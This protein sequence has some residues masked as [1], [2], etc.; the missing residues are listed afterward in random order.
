MT[1]RALWKGFITSGGRAEPDSPDYLR[2]TVM[3]LA[4]GTSVLVWLLFLVVNLSLPV[5]RPAPRIVLNLTGMAV[6]FL[7]ILVLR[8]GA[9]IRVMA[10]LVQLFLFVMLL[11]AALVKLNNP[12]AISVP[13]IYPAIAFLLLDSVPRGILWNLLMILCLNAVVFHGTAD[14]LGSA[15]VLANGALSISVAMFFQT[16]VV[17]LYLHNRQQVVERLLA[18]GRDLSFLASHDPLTGLYNRKDFTEVLDRE[19]ARR[20]QDS[21]H[22]AFLIFDIDRF[23]AYNDAYGHPRG[24]RLICRIAGAAKAVFS[25]REDMVFR[26]GGEEFGVVFRV[27]DRADAESLAEK[28]LASVEALGEPA[29]AGPGESLTVSAGLFIAEPGDH[30]SAEV[31]YQKADQALYNAKQSGRACFRVAGKDG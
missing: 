21:R 9:G 31:V 17:A 12:L 3:N 10:E 13:L 29:P 16:A 20:G 23:K 28:L 7:A 25:R 24:D 5:E 19:L 26:L 18:L 8:R 6:S 2:L 14:Y 11:G 4:L 22:L 15:E 30:P 1:W 27:E